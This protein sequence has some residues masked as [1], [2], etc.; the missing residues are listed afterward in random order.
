[1]DYDAALERLALHALA[2]CARGAASPD[3]ITRSSW[4]P[5]MGRPGWGLCLFG[6]RTPACAGCLL[7]RC[8]PTF[9]KSMCGRMSRCEGFL[10]STSLAWMLAVHW[11]YRLRGQCFT[12]P[13]FLRK[14]TW[15]SNKKRSISRVSATGFRK[16]RRD[17][18]QPMRDC[19]I[20]TALSSLRLVAHWST[21]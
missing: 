15:S 10:A 7:L 11:P 13:T 3:T 20:P 19:T 21:G 4:I 16:G 18:L 14:C 5:L 8:S 2:A 17:L 6:C 12:C 1:M 9:L